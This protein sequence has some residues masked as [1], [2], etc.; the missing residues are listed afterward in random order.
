M[1]RNI[2]AIFMI[3][4]LITGCSKKNGFMVDGKLQ[5]HNGEFIK[6]KRLDV[7][8]SVPVDS[9][10]IKNNG[11]FRLKVK[12]SA[13]EFYEVGFSDSDFITLLA[14]PGERIKLGFRGKYLYEDYSVAG[15]PGTSKLKMLDSTL[16]DT[17]QRIKTLRTRY[18][19][20]MNEP[21]FQQ[22]EEQIN[23]EFA[24]LL[25]VQRMYNVG[26]ILKNMSSF[27][28]V[29][30]L[31]QMID[32]NTYVLY[33]AR[34]LQY[35]KL[36]SDSLTYLYPASKQAKALKADFEKEYS[37]L[38]M[39]NARA[40]MNSLPATKL[41]PSL[42]DMNGKRIALSSLHGKYVLLAFWSAASEDCVADNLVLK[43]LYKKYR[44][45]GFEIYQINIDNDENKWKKAVKFD[46][47]PWISVRE[48]DPSNPKNAILYNA[49][50][51]PA[52]YLYDRDGNII[53]TN[54]HGR[55]LQLRLSQL[56]SN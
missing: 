9:V 14:G 4:I 28:S 33:D 31:Y 3:L 18:D 35:L 44:N 5:D 27:A 34:D 21:D 11:S 39:K 55:T 30:A 12:A 45:K 10:K 8:I 36:V 25:K 15:S 23:K 37:Q 20:A 13:P 16:A 51:L 48:D 52:N 46:E 19:N 38:Q 24:E 54:L 22:K 6:I 7:D 56:F 32:Q 29:K 41:D 49:R 1:S 17:K 43:E 2:P 40:L 50:V 42:K 47:L 26:F 53:G